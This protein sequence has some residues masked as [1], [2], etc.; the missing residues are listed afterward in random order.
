MAIDCDFEGEVSH[1]SCNFIQATDDQFDWMPNAGKTPT[2]KTGPPVDHTRGTSKGKHE[3]RMTEMQQLMKYVSTSA[4]QR[5]LQV[6]VLFFI[7][8]FYILRLAV[9][10]D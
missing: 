1:P 6:A 9:L 8:N 3:L 4:G 10:L 7:L 2:K 5:N